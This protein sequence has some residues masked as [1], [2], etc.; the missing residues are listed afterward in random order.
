M[1]NP[2]RRI[3]LAEDNTEEYI[4][5]FS[6]VSSISPTIEVIR[7]DDGYSLLN[8]VQSALHFD[9]VF[10]DINMKYKNGLLTLSEIKEMES[11]KTV[12]VIILSRSDFHYNVDVAYK[13]GATFYVYKPDDLATLSNILKTLFSSPFFNSGTQPPRDQFYIE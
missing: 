3:L 2:L 13:F 10:L 4:N 6:A 12:P 1:T 7:A 11:F 8:L 9:A 5:F